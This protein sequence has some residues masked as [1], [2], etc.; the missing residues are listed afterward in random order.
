MGVLCACTKKSNP[1]ISDQPS[2]PSNPGTESPI[3]MTPFNE[4]FGVTT[5]GGQYCL[6]DKPV[7]IETA[8]AIAGMGTKCIK[9]WFE[10]AGK[11]YPYHQIVGPINIT[12]W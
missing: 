10:H 6:T 8:E 12:F 11:K 9:L 5:A 4:V 2:A 1:Q 3:D 7:L